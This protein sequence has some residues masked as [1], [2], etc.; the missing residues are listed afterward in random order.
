MN[1]VQIGANDG[2][3]DAFKFIRAHRDEISCAVLVEPVLPCISKLM[4]RYDGYK[5]VHIENVAI[6][7][8][9]NVSSVPFF[10]ME[11]GQY[12]LSSIKK[13]H[14]IDHRVP[15]DKI[16]TIDV[17]CLTISNLLDKYKINYLEKLY[18]DA[19][20]YDYDIIKSINFAKVIIKEITFESMHIDGVHKKEQKYSDLL[21]FL[22]NS[23][24][25]V[26]TPIGL[27][28]VATLK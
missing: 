20:G 23:G 9:E 22:G 8:D 19:E 11:D 14:L 25:R 21:C 12:Q 10:Y 2:E 6:H 26:D 4:R 28:S 16:K 3:D 7:V 5:N 15:E 1:I 18:I 13:S 24:Y 17:K 27:N